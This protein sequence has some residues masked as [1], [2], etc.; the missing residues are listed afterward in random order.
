MATPAADL[1]V[2][3]TAAGTELVGVLGGLR[4]GFL[5]WLAMMAVLV[6]VVLV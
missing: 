3:L 1:I 5:R 2:V 4:E 6:V